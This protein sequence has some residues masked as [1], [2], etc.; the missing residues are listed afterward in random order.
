MTRSRKYKGGDV[1]G[2]ISKTADDAGEGI[3]NAGKKSW[4][5]F[6][7]LFG[8]K[9][10]PSIISSTTSSVGGKRKSRRIRGGDYTANSNLTNI[11]S[12]AAPVSGIETPKPCN[13]VGGRKRT[14]RHR[15]K[16]SRRRH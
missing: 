16:S 13:W 10:E 7:G 3:A 6:S 4:H 11:A 2:T 15:K 8:K 5:W 12:H 14:R 9:E 1:L